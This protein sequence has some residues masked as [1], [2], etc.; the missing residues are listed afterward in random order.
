MR[1]TKKLYRKYHHI[2]D[3][4]SSTITITIS[5]LCIRIAK[6][7][8]EVAR[9]S[10]FIVGIQHDPSSR[11]W[12][13][14]ELIQLHKPPNSEKNYVIDRIIRSHGHIPLRLPPYMCDFNAIELAWAQLKRFIR[15][16]N[17][18]GEFSIKVLKDLTEEGI[19]SITTEDW[20]KFCNHVQKIEDE[21]WV[22]DQHME[23]VEPLVIPLGN[24]SDSD[25]DSSDSDNDT[26]NSDKE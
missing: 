1:S 6:K 18:T 10:L 3:K 25:S 20:Q 9:K 24:D 2:R 13:L 19:S 7:Q 14:F 23:E 21:F 8:L 16:R 15:T 4:L 11:K 5:L 22:N 17:T 12:E 26:D